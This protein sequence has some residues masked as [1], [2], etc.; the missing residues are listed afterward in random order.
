MYSNERNSGFSV[1]DLLVKIIFAALFIFILVWLFQKK[2]PNMA[3]F[4]SNVFRE[5]IKY[6]QEA[7]ESYFTDDKLPKEIGGTAKITLSEM[8]DKKLILPF[9]DE[10][11]NSCNQY[12]SYVSITKTDIGYELKT[13]LVCNNETDYTIKV[14]G[15]YT[16]CENDNCIQPQ[17]K[18]CTTEEITQF[19]YKKL[20]KKTS[21]SYS[22]PSG[23]KRDGKYCYK[24]VLTD[25][26]SAEKTR[27]TKKTLTKNAK[28]V[29]TEG[30]KKLLSTIKTELPD[31]TKKVY[32]DPIKNTTS[33]ST[34]TEKEAYSC[35]KT[36]TE[37][38]T[39]SCTKTKT[40]RQAYDCTKSKTERQCTTTTK[41]EPYSCNCTTKYVGGV[42]KT[43]CDTCYNSVPV[44]TCKD[45]NVNYTDT[46]YRDVEVP[47]TTTCTRDKQVS[48]TDTCYRDK[49][50]TTPGTTTYS[51]PSKATHKSGSGANLK[52]Y[53]YETVDGGT[54]Y[55]CPS[56]SN[57]STGSGKNLKCYKVTNG[58]YY[59]TCSDSSYKLGSDNVCRKT[60]YGSY[61]EYECDKG[62]ELDGKVCK[63][64]TTKKVKATAK[65]K[66]SSSYTYKWS[67]KES[68]SGWTKTGKIKIVEGKTNCE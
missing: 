54:S 30:T 2:V 53:Y 29:V 22:C 9:V 41:K 64:Y 4:Y 18:K 5:N 15:C 62:Y 38:E 35:T 49:T 23:Y 46:C 25:T 17:E 51:C 7:G 61:T 27:T 26:E 3:P 39:Y 52:C 21:T 63:K 58:S 12:D 8:F 57:Y 32:L 56:N 60:V 10:D 47:Y 1:L 43:S 14:L 50:V 33:G 13:N 45:V 42:L 24:T 19:Q 44:Q 40:E 20:I 34:T 55:S 68:L 37:K 36:K 67:S 6:M 59:Y 65:T 31:T 11:G 16:Y 48:Y 66:T 28:L